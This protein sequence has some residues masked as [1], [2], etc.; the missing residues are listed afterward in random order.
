M[1]QNLKQRREELDA[2][3]RELDLRAQ[4][5]QVTQKQIDDRIKEL[6]SVQATIDGLL[7]K[8]DAQE[9]A[10]IQSL[11]KVYETMKPKEA[12]TIFNTLQMPVLI[13]L[14][15]RIKER[16]MA[17]IL[18]AM[19]PPAAKVLT[20]ELATRRSLPATGK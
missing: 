18:A 8:Y 11:V 2:R 20:V 12:A 9:E 6:Q 15:Q 13:E 5:L 14:A 16:T 3:E 4:L 17:P 19:D 1:L 10:K 7:V